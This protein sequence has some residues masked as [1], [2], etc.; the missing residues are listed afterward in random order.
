MRICLLVIISFY[1]LCQSAQINIP[2]KLPFET[3]EYLNKANV[4]NKYNF[5]KHEKKAFLFFDIHTE[6]KADLLANATFFVFKD[7]KITVFPIYFSGQLMKKQADN[8]GTKIPTQLYRIPENSIFSNFN[9]KE[10]DFPLLVVYDE[11]NTL[12][13][14]TKKFEEVTNIF[15]QTDTI[16]YKVMRLKMLVEPNN[17]GIKAYANKPIIVLSSKEN[18]TI[19]TV[20]TNVDGEINVEIPDLTKAYVIKAKEEDQNIKFIILGT[21]TGILLGKF[22]ANDEGFEYKVSQSKLMT[23]PGI[24]VEDPIEKKFAELKIKPVKS[25]VITETL[26]YELSESELTKSSKE[27]LVKIKNGLNSFPEYKLKIVSHTDSQGDDESNL[28][29]SIKRS[30][31]VVKYL[32]SIGITAERL[33]ADGKG[34]TEIRNRCVNGIDCSDKEHEYNRRTEFKFSK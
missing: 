31:S 28:N 22:K 17:N 14:I 21:Q 4:K 1:S 20:V 3:I 15:C 18:D 12:C 8:I 33:I 27:L 5:S 19:A 24:K 13:G 9:L 11:R 7:K 30:E 26:Y 34:E 10:S 6:Y 25:F 16:K 32:N 23:L 2:N 29:L